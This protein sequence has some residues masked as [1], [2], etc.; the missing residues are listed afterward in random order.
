MLGNAAVGVPSCSVNRSGSTEGSGIARAP[1]VRRAISGLN[2]RVA[3]EMAQTL[4]PGAHYVQT[5][6]QVGMAEERN[7]QISSGVHML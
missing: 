5:Y 2:E 4:A 3:V 1:Q 6:S 7:S